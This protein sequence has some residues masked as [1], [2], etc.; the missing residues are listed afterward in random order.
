MQRLRRFLALAGVDG[1]HFDVEWRLLTALLVLGV[2][3]LQWSDGLGRA[4]LVWYDLAMATWRRPA[5]AD[6]VLVTIDDESIAA[7][8]RWP[9]RR[10]IHATLL[11]KLAGAR[12][13]GLDLMLAEPDRND[14]AGDRILAQILAEHGRVVLPVVQ[15]VIEGARLAPQPPLAEFAAAAAGLG[16]AHAVTDAD[17][18]V[19]NVHL[20]EGTRPPGYPHFA[21]ALLQFLQPEQFPPFPEVG[22]GS[23]LWQRT[24]LLPVA[25][26]GSPGHFRRVSYVEVLQGKVPEAEFRNKIVLVGVT[27]SGFG[28]EHATPVSAQGRPMAGVELIANAFDTLRSD[29]TLRTAPPL[30][31]ILLS[32]L[33]I[34]AAMAALR[35]SSPRR[36]LALAF[37]A[38]LLLLL[39]TLGLFR[40]GQVWFPPSATLLALALAY[41]LWSWRRLEATQRYLDTELALLAAE[42]GLFGLSGLQEVVSDPLLWRMAAVKLAAQRMRDAR[43]FVQDVVNSLPVGVLVADAQ[44]KVVIANHKAAELM[45]LSGDSQGVGETLVG[46][47]GR[48]KSGGGDSLVGQLR[49]VTGA[50][51]QVEVA[52]AVVPAMLLQ[53]VPCF[54]AEG[55][56][57]GLIATL[58][59]ISE[60]RAMRQAREDTMR[61]LSH[62]LRAPL[63]SILTLLESGSDHESGELLPRIERHAR[64]SLKLADDLLRL[65]RAE[66]LDRGKFL[67]LALENILE[68]AL[69]EVWPQARAR[70]IDLVNRIS[71]AQSGEDGALIRGDAESLRRV[72]VN[73]LTN[74]IKFSPDASQVRLALSS[75]GQ[76]W[77]V[78][79][80]DSGPGITEEDRQKLFSRFARLGTQAKRADGVGLG[81]VIVKTVVEAHGGQVDVASTPGRGSCFIVDLPK[82][83]VSNTSL[84]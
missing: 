12:V 1:R 50:S 51:L 37:G 29:I 49:R 64:R 70:R 9:W 4:D 81:L 65:A 30:L 55:R 24:G 7:V 66:A 38:G 54:S 84:G 25:F 21:L 15:T 79:V 71:D 33:V 6:V 34:Y 45:G 23:G 82:A 62:D 73:L 78:I 14:A 28:D 20:A 10:A 3:V 43:R 67:E 74:A 40:W 69:D 56:R 41:P 75:F 2:A 52:S 18:L 83:I 19:R 80:V 46:L 32:A 44:L 8:G 16:Q 22:E 53:V 76:F 31:Q 77:Q 39:L 72:F 36:G 11:Q 47:L 48:L 42:P 68:E 27:A 13:V 26:A 59:D 5:P 57:L 58:V 60:L 61:Y 63:V 17:G 35:R